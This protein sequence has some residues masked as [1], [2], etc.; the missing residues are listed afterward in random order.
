MSAITTLSE[1]AQDN[2]QV[3][4]ECRGCQRRTKMD[5]T[6]L[7]HQR[8]NWHFKTAGVM[9]FRCQ[10]CDSSQSTAAVFVPRA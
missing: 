7:L 8:P 10:Q 4:I 6:A 1:A 2:L 3:S 5:A 9:R